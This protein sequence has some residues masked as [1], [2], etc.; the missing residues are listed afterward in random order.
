MTKELAN[1]L[2]E[3]ARA[4]PLSKESCQ[5]IEDA[6]NI[7]D[8][9]GYDSTADTLL[10]MKEVTKGLLLFSKLLMSRAMAHDESK[11]GDI[12]KPHF[13]RETPNL[14]NLVYNSPEYKESLGR[15]Q[16]ALQH[17]YMANDHHPEFYQSGVSGMNLLAVVEMFCDWVAASKR[18]KGGK[19]DLLSSYKRFGF[20]PQLAAINTNTAITLGVPLK[21]EQS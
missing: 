14:K 15:L 8:T 21:D 1:H 3:I 11:L 6:A 4:S 19:L 7:L 18:N 2:H 9:Q 5:A 16:A 17:H 20:D 12:E 10:H 13:D